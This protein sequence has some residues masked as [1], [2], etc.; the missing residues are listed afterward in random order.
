MHIPDARNRELARRY[1]QPF[2]PRFQNCRAV[3]EIAS[4]QGHFLEMLK[5]AGIPATGIELDQELCGIARGKGLPVTQGDFFELL[6]KSA[7]GSYDGAMASH[8]VEHF[9][10]VRVEELFTLLRQALKPGSPLVVV[11][12]NIAYI[13]SAVGDFWRDPTH[14][15]P[16]P[17]QALSKLFARTGWEVVASGEHVK[18]GPSLLRA[19]KYGLRNLIFGRF[20]VNDDIFVV[21]KRTG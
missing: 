12:P 13:R 2:I 16:Y 3:V 6:G 18:R 8:I 4:G 21:A 14:V 11:T 10:P 1:F 17:I 5:E 15:R 19:I 20:W 7:P 9:P